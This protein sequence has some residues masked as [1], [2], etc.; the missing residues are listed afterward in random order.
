[1]H[2]Y[3]IGHGGYVVGDGGPSM[4]L[5]LVVDHDVAAAAGAE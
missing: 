5:L 4:G 1:M 2:D 3:D